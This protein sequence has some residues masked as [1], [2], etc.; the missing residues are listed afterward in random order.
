MGMPKQWQHKTYLQIDCY[1]S[2]DDLKH[3]STALSILNIAD[4]RRRYH[5]RLASAIS[6]SG[7]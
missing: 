6:V 5:Q 7:D 1:A 2:K 4:A 3:K